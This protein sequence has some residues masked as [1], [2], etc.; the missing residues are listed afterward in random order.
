VETIRKDQTKTLTEDEL[1]S[2]KYKGL[3]PT[4]ISSVIRMQPSGDGRMMS[5]ITDLQLEFKDDAYHVRRIG[6]PAPQNQNEQISSLETP[7][8]NQ[9]YP[10]SHLYFKLLDCKKQNR[11]MFQLHEGVPDDTIIEQIVIKLNLNG[12]HQ[13]R[14]ETGGNRQAVIWLEDLQLRICLDFADRKCSVE[15]KQSVG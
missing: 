11:Q 14:V 6:D 4:S 8:H 12:Y 2:L 10:L 3:C 7:A 15:S 13:V 9:G 5:R 1:G